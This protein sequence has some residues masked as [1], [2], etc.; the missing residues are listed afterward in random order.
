M[1]VPM[2]YSTETTPLKEKTIFE[3]WVFEQCNFHWLIAELDV[4]AKLA[5]GYAFLNDKQNAEWGYISITE[6]ESIGAVKD[7]S[8]KPKKASEAIKEI[9]KGV[10]E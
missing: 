6:I 10:K 7:K 1:R 2:L 3:H 9:L 5:F 8:F 4:K